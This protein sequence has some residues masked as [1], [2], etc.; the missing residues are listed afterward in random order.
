MISVVAPGRRVVPGV[1]VHYSRR[2]GPL[3]VVTFHGIPVTNVARL[4]VDL[5]DVLIAEELTNVMHE[6]AFR[7][8]LHLGA[9]RRAMQ[10]AN[11]CHNLHALDEAIDLYLNGSAG[12]K[13]LGEKAF[14]ALVQA[15]GIAK[16]LVN[17]KVAGLEVDFHWPGPPTDRGGRWPGTSTPEREASG[18]PARRQAAGRRLGGAAHPRCGD[19]ARPAWR[20]PANP[21][22]PRALKG[23]ERDQA[24]HGE[25]Q[26]PGGAVAPRR[27]AAGFEDVV[28]REQ[29]EERHEDPERREKG[30]SHAAKTSSG[31]RERR[32][33]ERCAYGVVV[34][35]VNVS[36]LRVGAGAQ[37]VGGADVLLERDRHQVVGDRCRSRRPC[38]NSTT[39][40]D[41]SANAPFIRWPGSET[42]SAASPAVEITL[43]VVDAV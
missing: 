29:Q 15:A 11:G 18:R 2:L 7:G 23:R 13:S 6:A 1:E 38:E 30:E 10:R 37:R 3:D 20:D 4:L 42:V 12:L 35:S 26:A 31:R 22:V 41:G 28:G 34:D 14:L 32:P 24:R 33:E 9:T 19:R 5:T 27:R 36:V 8:L 39:S 21:R 16:P 43:A 17:T 25:D 40:G